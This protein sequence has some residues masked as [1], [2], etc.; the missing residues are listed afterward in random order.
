MSRNTGN[1]TGKIVWGT[2]NIDNK[3]RNRPEI[4]QV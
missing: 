2:E 3:K 4:K 1:I